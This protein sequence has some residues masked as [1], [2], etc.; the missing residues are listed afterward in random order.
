MPKTHKIAIIGKGFSGLATA[1]HLCKVLKNHEIIVY[2]DRIDASSISAGL[3]HRFSGLNA[4]AN[5][6]GEEALKETEELLLVSSQALLKPVILSKG[7]LRLATTPDQA[8]SFASTAK[9]YPDVKWMSEEEVHAYDPH[10]IAKP[11]IFIK[12]GMTIDTLGYLEGLKIALEK[13]GVEFKSQHITD[14]FSF[15]PFDIVVNCMGAKAHQLFPYKCE[16]IFP[17]KGQLLEILWPS[18]LP[19]LTSAVTSKVYI[20][21]TEV[22]GQACI[23]A[24]FE[25][26]FTQEE[27]DP[28]F[29]INSLLPLALEIYPELHGVKILGVKSGL[30]ASTP[31]HLPIF[32]KVSEKYWI[33]SGMGSKGLL[34]HAF[35][36]KKL[37]AAIAK[38]LLH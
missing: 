12:S 24:T 13:L 36:A 22:A 6:Y 2:S 32:G 17:L 7:I 31:T 19:K 3:L 11:G 4:K 21:M 16:K 28:E 10:L 1:W 30:R 38:S 23:G 18:H 27:K 20:A 34:Y 9:E 26:T 5:R 35:F 37:A 33:L 8:E 15:E 14:S 29:A 25:H